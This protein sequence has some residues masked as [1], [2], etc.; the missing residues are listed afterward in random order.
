MY[1]FDNISTG[2]LFI[3]DGKG[4]YTPFMGIQEIKELPDNEKK[5][6]DDF[7]ASISEPFA[8]FTITITDKRACK[9]LRRIFKHDRFIARKYIRRAARAKEKARREKVKRE[10]L[11]IR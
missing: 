1:P 9:R 2:Q 6:D 8:T 3:G 11:P 7:A 5:Y 4:N 10:G